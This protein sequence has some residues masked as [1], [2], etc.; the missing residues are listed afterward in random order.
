[1]AIRS[2]Q[3]LL[4]VV[5]YGFNTTVRAEINKKFQKQQELNINVPIS[6]DS[7]QDKYIY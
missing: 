5:I 6:D 7:N 1:M 2:L 3:G 4:D